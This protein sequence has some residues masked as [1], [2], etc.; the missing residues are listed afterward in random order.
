LIL[1]IAIKPLIV[2]TALFI[3]HNLVP[4]L[5]HILSGVSFIA[6]LLI[7][8]LIDDFLQYWYHR[9]AHEYPF[10]WK[11]HRPH[12]QAEQMGFF[13]SYRNAALYYILMPNLWWIGF[14]TYLGGAKAIALGL[15]LKQLIIISSHSTVHYDKWLNKYSFSRF[16]LS[17]WERLFITPAFHHAHH[18]KSKSDGISDP[19]G[20]FGNMFSIW[21]QLFGTAVFNRTFPKQYGLFNDPKEEWSA[22]YFY[23]FIKSKDLTSEISKHYKKV[24]TTSNMA[25]PVSLEP[26]QN[27]LWCQ[28]GKSKKQPFCDGSHHGTK[29]KPV[30]F[31]VSK[32]SMYKLCNCKQSKTKPFCDNTHLQLPN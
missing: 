6:G 27:Y 17:I 10:L 1:A 13:V 4:Q 2:F 23:P 16:I 3:T 20:N 15:F 19:N 11:L 30:L 18:G 14:Y 31:Q 7:Y 26:G 5:N 8:L 25:I 24:A 32:K 22:A 21:D 29:H 28:C 9:S 12:H